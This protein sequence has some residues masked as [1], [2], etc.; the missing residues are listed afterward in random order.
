ML[1]SR[2]VVNTGCSWR[3]IEDL[4][5]ETLSDHQYIEVILRNTRQPLHRPPRGGG[6]KRWTLTKLDEEKLEAALMA[7]SWSLPEGEVGRDIHEKVEWLRGEM[8]KVCDDSMPRVTKSRP[9]RAT[10]WWTEELAELRRST[11]RARRTLSRIP[12]QGREEETMEALT[13]YRAARS[14][15][16]AIRKSR[17]RCWD[18]LLA[19]LNADPWGVHIK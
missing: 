10:Y 5:V 8:H 9:K 13:T 4:R 12:R 15:L 17:A 2:R 19:S 11:V 3:V 18:E 16:S 7:V 14:A 1:G 6:E